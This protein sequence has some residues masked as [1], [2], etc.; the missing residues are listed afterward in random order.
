MI[1]SVRSNWPWLPV[2]GYRHIDTAQAYDNEECVGQAIEES[3]VPRDQIFLTTKIWID[4]FAPDHFAS[5]LETSLKK[6]RTD[7]VDLLLIHWPVEKDAS[8]EQQIREL[9]HIQAAGKTRLIGV[10]NFNVAQM[11]QVCDDIGAPVACNQ[12]EYH[13]FLD[14][15]PVLDE[16]RAQEMMVTA[17]SPLARGDVMKDPTIKELAETYGKNA[18]QITLR[19]L[20][21]QDG[22][23]AIPK[24]A[25][26]K[27]I[28]NN[29]EIFDF[30]LSSDDMKRLHDLA[31]PDGRLINPEWA[32]DWDTGKAKAA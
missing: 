29:F 4:N 7:Y 10:S 23:A 13:P 31:R 27:H 14:Q 9:E 21:Q 1:A 3:E 20:I 26:D 5:S 22:V 18:A 28:I 2:T 30:E 8:F 24:S 16:A 12:V 19:W 25:T 15:T 32:P 6:L 17:Y 11:R